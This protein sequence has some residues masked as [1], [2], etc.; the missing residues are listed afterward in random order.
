MVGWL[1]GKYRMNMYVI[2]YYFLHEDDWNEL[3]PLSGKLGGVFCPSIS[4][5]TLFIFV[6]GTEM[7]A[8]ISQ[9]IYIDPE[10]DDE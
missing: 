5:E 4:F 9:E 10:I 2:I 3:R 7:S 1:P 6:V 8:Q